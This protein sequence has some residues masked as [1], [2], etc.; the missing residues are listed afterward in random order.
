MAAQR[1]FQAFGE[2]VVWAVLDSGIQGDHPHFAQSQPHFKG[3]RGLAPVVHRD[4]T[5]DGR[6][7]NP[8]ATDADPVSDAT[9]LLDR[10]GHGTHVAGIIAGSWKSGVEGGEA[11]IGSEIRDE[12][13]DKAI[14]PADRNADEYFWSCSQGEAGQ[15]EGDCG[16]SRLGRGEAIARQGQSQLDSN[17]HRSDPKV[18]SIWQAALGARSES[19][20]GIRFRS[21]LVRLRPESACVWK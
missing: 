13:N 5:P 18:E 16:C 19:K 6:M 9:A 8:P 10:F 3:G 12:R 15:P 2:G 21:A 7:T 4:F 17:G 14:T 20:F 11:V 1:S